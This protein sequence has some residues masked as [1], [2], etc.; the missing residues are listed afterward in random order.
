MEIKD[1][2]VNVRVLVNSFDEHM[3]NIAT[4]DDSLDSTRDRLL[5]IKGKYE[6]AGKEDNANTVE[7]LKE[8]GDSLDR[9][10][11]KHK[12][13][14]AKVVGDIQSIKLVLIEIV[15]SHNN[16]IITLKKRK[17]VITFKRAGIVLGVVCVIGAAVYVG[18]DHNPEAMKGVVGLLGGLIKKALGLMTMAL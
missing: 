6:Q 1:K 11:K 4:T 8:V 16:D 2:L 12:I 9:E 3:I 17:P 13:V 15:E 10:I 18:Y 14:M 7:L 5:V